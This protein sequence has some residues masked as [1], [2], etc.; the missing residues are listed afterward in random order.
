MHEIEELDWIEPRGTILTQ[1]AGSHIE[2]MEVLYFCTQA[3]REA[4]TGHPGT[5]HQGDISLSLHYSVAAIS[6]LQ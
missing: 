2:S 1:E 4:L 3:M 6:A 5:C